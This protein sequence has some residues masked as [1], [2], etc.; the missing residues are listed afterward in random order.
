MVMD[1]LGF[2]PQETA[3]RVALRMP[4][5]TLKAYGDAA[6]KGPVILLVPAPI[7]RAYIWDL[8]PGA[9]VVEQCLAHETRPYVV[10]WEQPEAAFGL[11][12]YADRL[13][14]ACVDAIR[15]E[16][17]ENSV[18]LAGHSL[19]GLLAAIF[20]SLHPQRL[21]GLI[22][23]TAP[24]H[25]DF[26]EAA[27][28]LGPVIAEIS[29]S[30]LLVAAPG[31]LPGSLL[32]LASFLASPST[33]GRDRWADWVQGWSDARAVKLHLRVERWSLD[34][35]PLARQLVADIEQCLYREDAFLRGTLKSGE[36]T[37]SA[38]GVVAP[39]LIVADARCAVVPPQAILPFEQAS[40]AADKHLL[41]YQGDVGVAIQ[42]VGVL[43][44]RTALQQL[45]PAI[46]HWVHTH[47]RHSRGQSKSS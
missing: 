8:A 14:L 23:L 41:W 1:M 39:L 37:A 42:H 35:M 22:A 43:V 46:L 2:G 20:A 31:N 34:E 45:W 27:G 44:G 12:D 13:V 15:A 11:D 38:R 5:L 40:G 4:G 36:R 28:V 7:K 17:G 47:W 9:S 10:Q 16:T 18:F 29:R 3:S 25:F 26:D 24:L 21:Q 33:F 6:G 19:G 32:S 30:G